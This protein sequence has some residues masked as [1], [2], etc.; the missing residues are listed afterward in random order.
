MPQNE[1]SLLPVMRILM[2]PLPGIS[3]KHAN[4][5]N[6]CT[7]CS[8]HA[9]R[10]TKAIV[11]RETLVPLSRHY[12]CHAALAFIAVDFVWSLMLYLNH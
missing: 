8:I 11:I 6:R 2:Q 12:Y 5:M 9:V 1:S 4:L 7:F 10:V 3:F